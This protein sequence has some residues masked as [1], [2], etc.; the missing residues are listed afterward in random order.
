MTQNQYYAIEEAIEN[1][2]DIAV[3]RPLNWDQLV[4]NNAKNIKSIIETLHEAE[5]PVCTCG[6]KKVPHIVA[7]IKYLRCRD[8]G[9]RVVNE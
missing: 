7:P 3:L 8:C 2:M 1:L 6:S 4:V 9:G 5:V